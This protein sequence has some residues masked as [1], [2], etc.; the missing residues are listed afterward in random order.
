MRLGSV[1]EVAKPFFYILHHSRLRLAFLLAPCFASVPE[2][3]QLKIPALNKKLQEQI[4]KSTYGEH[5]KS[6]TF[7]SFYKTRSSLVMVKLTE[8]SQYMTQ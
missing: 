5:K 3:L 4:T 8:I 2:S 6:Y 1:S 7:F